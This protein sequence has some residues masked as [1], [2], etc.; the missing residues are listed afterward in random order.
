M[1]QKKYHEKRRKRIQADLGASD[2]CLIDSH[3]SA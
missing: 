3:K 1:L 2:D